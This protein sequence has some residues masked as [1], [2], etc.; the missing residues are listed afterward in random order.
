VIA[1]EDSTGPSEV[2]DMSIRSA[3]RKLPTPVKDGIKDRVYPQL[4]PEGETAPEWH[5]QSWDDS[6]H[7]LGRHWSLMFFFS[8][9]SGEADREQLRSLQAHLPDFDRLKTKVFAIHVAEGPEHKAL[10]EELGLSFPI[11]TDRGGPVARLFRSC[12]QLPVRPVY[13]S[14]LYLI[15]PERKVRLSNRGQPSVEAVVRS[16]EA[17]QRATRAGM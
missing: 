15:N 2:R 8:D 9:P 5:L 17:L 6:W 10:A 13:L 16:I 12:V 4:L 1:F 11:L 14:A 7:R 3:L